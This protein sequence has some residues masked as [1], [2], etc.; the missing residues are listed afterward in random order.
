MT[1][2]LISMSNTYFYVSYLPSP[3]V[4]ISYLCCTRCTRRIQLTSFTSLSCPLDTPTL[5]FTTPSIVN[6]GVLVCYFYYNYTCIRRSLDW[7]V[8][9]TSTLIYLRYTAHYMTMLLIYSLKH[10]APCTTPRVLIRRE[11]RSNIIE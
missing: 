4:S 5:P 11:G 2:C 9:L 8:K 1:Q 3:R 6:G 7:L 10:R